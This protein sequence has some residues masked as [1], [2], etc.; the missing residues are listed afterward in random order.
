MEQNPRIF[1]DFSQKRVENTKNY[2]KI[3]NLLA[4]RQK[5]SGQCLFQ[6]CQCC[7]GGTCTCPCGAYCISC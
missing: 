4:T 1:L 6:G 7:V 3:Y 5:A 2:I